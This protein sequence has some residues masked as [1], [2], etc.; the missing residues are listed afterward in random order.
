[1]LHCL[2][3]AINSDRRYNLLIMTEITNAELL[4][5]LTEKGQRCSISNVQVNDCVSFSTHSIISTSSIT[6]ENVT[7][8]NQ[9]FIA[10]QSLGNGIK[11]INCTF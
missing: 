8:V 7:F 1:M 5:K 11:F 4:T 2:K 6:F 10:D 9:V 3:I